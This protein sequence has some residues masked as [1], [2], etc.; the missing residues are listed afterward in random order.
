[1]DRYAVIGHPVEHSRSPDIHARF[2][3]ETGQSL[4]YRHLLSPLDGFTATARAFADGG[5]RGCNVTVPFKFE[6]WQLATRRTPRAQRAEAA[7]TLRFDAEGWWCDNTDGIGLVRDITVNA[8][9]ALAGRRVL[10]I[11][12]GGAAAGVLGP[13]IEAGPAALVVANRT[14]DKAQ[15]LVARHADLAHDHGVALGIAPLEAP[16]EAFDIVINGTASSL[17][18][19]GVPVPGEVLRPGALAVDMMYGAGARPFLDWAARHGAIGRDGL[20]MLVE[21]AAESFF[22]WRGA[23][24]DTAPVLSALRAQVDGLR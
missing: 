9:V 6:A 18:G 4:D 19:A 22:A 17:A 15:A 11:G 21:Q 10:L 3:A 2:A 8:G 1:M 12:A 16:G 23:R 20:G 14:A 13:L 24:P 7:N 5:A